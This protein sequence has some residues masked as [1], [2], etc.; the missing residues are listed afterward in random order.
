MDLGNAKG[1][2]ITQDVGRPIQ[3]NTGG[4]TDAVVQASK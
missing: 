4:A 3:S 1:V 2:Q